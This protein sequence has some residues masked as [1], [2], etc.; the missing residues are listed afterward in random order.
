MGTRAL[1]LEIKQLDVVMNHFN[2][3]GLKGLN[4][5]I[6]AHDGSIIFTDKG[7]SGLQDPWGRV[8]RISSYGRADVLLRNCLSPNG[9]IVDAL[10][11]SLFI[12]MSRDNNVWL[13]S[14]YSDGSV[15]RTG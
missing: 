8:Y 13:V 7:M 9:L 11:S 14:L 1:D 5:L 4:D 15:Q 6:V 12:A 2:E 10:Q 3:E